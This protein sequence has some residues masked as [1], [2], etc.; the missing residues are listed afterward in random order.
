MCFGDLGGEVDE[1][2][3]QLDRRVD[4][5][6]GVVGS[7]LGTPQTAM[8]PSPM[9]FVTPARLVLGGRPQ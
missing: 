1:A 2:L 5:V 7:D 3:L 9:Y 6:G 8:N 4:G